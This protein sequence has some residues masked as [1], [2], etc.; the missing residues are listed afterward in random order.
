MNTC[1]KDRPAANVKLMRYS[2]DYVCR[3]CSDMY[4]TVEL[5]L[6]WNPNTRECVTQCPDETPERGTSKICLACKEISSVYQYWD[7]ETE[8][9]VDSC[10]HDQVRFVEYDTYYVCTY[11]C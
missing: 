6:Y 4:P 5:Q 11:R 7:T 3:K 1:P 9:C 8:K 2:Y 10:P